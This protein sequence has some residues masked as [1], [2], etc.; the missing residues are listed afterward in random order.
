MGFPI[1]VRCH[2]YIESGPWCCLFSF[3]SYSCCVLKGDLNLLV[4][5]FLGIC[6]FS[7]IS[8]FAWWMALGFSAIVV[9]EPLFFMEGWFSR[10]LGYFGR[11]SW[12]RV[13]AV[14]FIFFYSQVTLFFNKYFLYS[15]DYLVSCWD[16]SVPDFLRLFL[17][18]LLYTSG[19]LNEVGWYKVKLV[20]LLINPSWPPWLKPRVSMCSLVKATFEMS[21]M[22]L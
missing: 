17:C 6:F 5:F 16:C 22:S 7:L 1:L 2:L 9:T 4:N 18:L 8:F 3:F 15:S 21:Q 20:Q 11:T 14:Y 10:F 13:C 12:M 19:A